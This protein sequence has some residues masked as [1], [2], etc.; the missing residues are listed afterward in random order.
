MI[1]YIYKVT[2]LK[3]GKYYIGK[4]S[5]KGESINED[6]YMGSGTLI[7]LALKKYGKFNFKKEIIAI[8]SS[9]DEVNKLERDIITE[10]I[11]NDENSYNIALG[12]WGGNLGDIVNRKIKVI[13]ESEE[14]RNKMSKII[15]SP[16]VKE[17]MISSIKK[18]MSEIGWKENF[19]KIQKDVQNKPENRL[20]NSVKQKLAQNRTEV[21]KKKSDTMN[22]LYNDNEFK[23]KHLKACQ[24]ES[25]KEKQR[26][27]VIGKKWVNNS[28]EQKYVLEINLPN[29][30][31]DGWVL[32]M[33]KR[34]K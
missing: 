32:G 21:I 27:K 19:S 20:R 12:G 3:N 17:K 23:N 24:S 29:L 26:N 5:F 9:Y 13:C 6:K 8:C 15:N 22:K 4:R 11:I 18:T 28:K 16:E 34:K 7:K 14:Y 33:L 10:E 25:F 30:L 1:H 31:N 2:N